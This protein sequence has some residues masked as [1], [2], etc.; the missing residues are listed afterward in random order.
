MVMATEQLPPFVLAELYPHS[1]VILEPEQ[2]NQPEQQPAEAPITKLQEAL[3]QLKKGEIGFSFFGN[4]AKKICIIVED[5][6]A[7]YLADMDLQ[8][9]TNVL[10]ACKL[11]IGDVAIVNTARSEVSINIIKEQLTPSVCLL[12]GMD[13]DAIGL[14]FKIPAYQQQAY[15]GCTFLV[16]PNFDRFAGAAEAAKLE[17]TKLWVSLQKLLNI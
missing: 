4:N 7:V 2:P 1:L 11:N 3:P 12:F 5:H 15:A 14:P 8:F 13:A 10:N 9:L 6:T 16:L 17:K